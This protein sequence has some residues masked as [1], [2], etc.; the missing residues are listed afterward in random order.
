MIKPTKIIRHN[1]KIETETAACF[2]HSMMQTLEKVWESFEST[3]LINKPSPA[4]LVYMNFRILRN[5]SI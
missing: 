2:L 3:V 4:A 1:N 5:D